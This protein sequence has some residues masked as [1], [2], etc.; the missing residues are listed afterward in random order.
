MK[1]LNQNIYECI[2]GV[3]KD[4][5][6]GPPTEGGDEF[7]LP[8]VVPHGVPRA[9]DGD[10]EG[11]DAAP[12]GLAGHFVAAVRGDVADAGVNAGEGPGDGGP[13]IP[14]GG[15]QAGQVV[16]LLN[17]EEPYVVRRQGRGGGAVH[18]LGVIDKNDF[19]GHALVAL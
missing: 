16:D 11:G 15:Q 17:L 8:I 2:T 12:A 1:K 14:F 9:A 19:V 7:S 6:H 3:A 10:D 5:A 18:R 13:V 4:L